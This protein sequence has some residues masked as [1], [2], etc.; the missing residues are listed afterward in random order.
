MD[1]A[2]RHETVNGELLKQLFVVLPRARVK[3]VFV[4]IELQK[5]CFGAAQGGGDHGI[6]ALL[7]CGDDRKRRACFVHQHE[8][9]FARSHFWRRGPQRCEGPFGG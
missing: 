2:R 9:P 5:R 7:Q 6:A 3:P 4:R 8:R 1:D